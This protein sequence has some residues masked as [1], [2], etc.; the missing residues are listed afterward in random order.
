MPR[1][2]ANVATQIGDQSRP[3]QALRESQLQAAEAR[4]SEQTAN[5]PRELTPASAEELKATAER[6]RQV[7][8]VATGRQLDFT[9][10]ERFREVIVRI[11][12]RKSGEIL[13]EIPS[14]E[15]IKLR[16]RLNDLIGMFI[17]ERA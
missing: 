11:S 13:K 4:R 16:E 7:I 12:D 3:Y 10:N 15:L 17:D 9:L 1:I 5:E 14:K 6:L 2:D 8:E